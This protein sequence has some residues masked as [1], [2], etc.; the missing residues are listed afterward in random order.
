MR[1]KSSEDVTRLKRDQ[2]L[3]RLKELEEC[4]VLEFSL[5]CEHATIELVVFTEPNTL[6]RTIEENVVQTPS[7]TYD[8]EFARFRF[9]DIGDFRKK[10]GA[11]QFYNQTHFHTKGTA[12]DAIYGIL[13]SRSGN[14]HVFA[15]C[16]SKFGSIE[17]SFHNVQFES[18]FATIVKEETV[19]CHYDVL[20]NE[21]IDFCN[22][23]PESDD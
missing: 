13:V 2:D 20:T 5:D 6:S 16:L 22:P 19:F 10:G 21:L 4:P 8:R 11:K 7:K 23:F 3:F 1:Q 18:R 9:S 15:A 12:V 17:F 14:K